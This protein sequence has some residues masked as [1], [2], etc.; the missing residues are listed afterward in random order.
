MPRLCI[1]E[2]ENDR[3]PQATEKEKREGQQLSSLIGTTVTQHLHGGK[4][5]ADTESLR[6]RE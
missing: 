2:A 1:I 4:W 3:Q 5:F 6:I